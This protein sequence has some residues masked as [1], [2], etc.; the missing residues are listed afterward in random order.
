MD[1]SYVIH[2]QPIIN[3]LSSLC[4]HGGR[5]DSS[6]NQVD[7]TMFLLESYITSTQAS[8]WQYYTTVG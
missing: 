7:E 3:L 5:L 4:A 6:E 1:Q 8:R 2:V